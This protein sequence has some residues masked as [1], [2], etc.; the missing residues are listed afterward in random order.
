MIKLDS[1]VESCNTLNDLSNKV[2][3]PN[4]TDD[5][6]LSIFKI[7]T[8]INQ[9]KALTKYL[10]CECKCRFDEKKSNSNHWWNNGKCQCECKKHR[11]YEK[12][13][14]SIVQME[15]V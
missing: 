8:G 5:L 14:V 10:L 2:C 12:D 4:K 11:I 1:C 9:S 3:I 7:I 6:N 15:N 13:Y